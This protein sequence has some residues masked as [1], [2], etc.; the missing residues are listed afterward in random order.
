MLLY[1]TWD[2]IGSQTGGGQVTFNELEA[3][4]EIGETHVINPSMTTNP[5]DAD[6]AALDQYLIEGKKYKLAHFYSSSYPSLVK[7][8]KA[9]G[10]KISYTVA[11]HNVQV[12]Q[13]EHAKLGLSF[14]HPHLTNPEL[15]SRYLESYLLSDIVICPSYHSH[16]IMLNNR[17]K[18]IIVIPHGISVY[19]SK[20]K[21]VNNFSVGYLGAIGPDKG[22]IYLLEAWSQLNYPDSLLT[23][24]GKNSTD[25]LPL[26]RQFKGNIHLAGF[27][28]DLDNFYNSINLYVQP[29]ATEGFG[30]EV[31]EA[32]SYGKAVVVTNSTGAADCVESH[33]GMISASCC[34]L[35]LADKINYYKEHSN[36]LRLHGMNARVKAKNFTWDKIKYRYKKVWYELLAAV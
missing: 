20:I 17:C 19:P 14:D 9:D 5:F 12:S 32:M 22:L 6:K 31:L 23:I 1:V 28:D 4:K 24:A 3:L 11:A 30:I 36:V 2:Q 27:I 26:V 7:Q 35:G 29:S 21:D 25:L 10:T 34:S 8:L 18:K 13:R 33:E 16:D 15:W